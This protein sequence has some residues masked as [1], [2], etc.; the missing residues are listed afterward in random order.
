MCNGVSLKEV[1][2]ILLRRRGSLRIKVYNVVVHP[3]AAAFV[4]FYYFIFF[5][6]YFHFLFWGVF[7]CMFFFFFAKG[8]VCMSYI[9]YSKIEAYK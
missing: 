8:V 4:E 2:E 9:C 6:P 1:S 7:M 5:M 3:L